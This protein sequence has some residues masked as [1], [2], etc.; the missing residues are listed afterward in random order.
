[1][2]EGLALGRSGAVSA[3]MDSSDGLAWCLHELALQSGVGFE[4]SALPVAAEVQRFAD[5]NELD[6][7]ELALYGGEEYELVVTVKPDLWVKAESA[8]A[9]VGGKL[10]RIG[11]ATRDKRVLLCID[12]EKRKIEARGYEHFKRG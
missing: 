1:L 10:L 9:S 12:G 6:A 8:V 7:G 11:Q 2:Q 4:V 3:S 5:L